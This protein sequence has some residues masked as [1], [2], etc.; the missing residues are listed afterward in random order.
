MKKIILILA[1][2]YFPIVSNA[3]TEDRYKKGKQSAGQRLD[4]IIDNTKEAI[5]RTR[6]I[7][8]AGGNFSTV[9]KLNQEF[10]FGFYVGGGVRIPAVRSI[11]FS[12]Q[13]ELLLESMGSRPKAII[14]NPPINLRAAVVDTTS[15]TT[16]ST[17]NAQTPRSISN[18]YVSIPFMLFLAPSE[19]RGIYVEA[20]PKLGFA[21][22]KGNFTGDV[23]AN[24]FDFS[25]AFGL[26]AE[27]KI[28]DV[29]GKFGIGGRYNFGLTNVYKLDPVVS[30]KNSSFSAG[31]KYIF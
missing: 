25:L 8:S 22:N 20:G 28:A 29:P 9:T 16:S 23:K 7:V 21:I 26:G 15:S 24:T 17:T 31:L 11:G 30:N 19:L 18:L 12:I 1:F 2:I 14:P 13:P 10:V 5:H 4:H 6:Y 27:F 3:Q